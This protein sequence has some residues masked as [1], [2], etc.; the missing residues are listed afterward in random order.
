MEVRPF[1]LWPSPLAP[2]DLAAATRFRDLAWDSD[3][4][5]LV[6]LEGRGPQGTLVCQPHGEAPRDLNTTLSVRAQVGYGG[7][8]FAVARGHA[9]FVEYSGR[10]YRQALASGPAH[11]ITPEFGSAASPTPSPDG[12][13]L[14]Y[15]HSDEGRDSLAVVDTEGH[16]WPQRLDDWSTWSG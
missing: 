12:R 2:G 6:W 1:G 3:G 16:H 13:H 14:V 10:L 9:Y 11:P 5:T 8:D 4:R 7:G 15:V